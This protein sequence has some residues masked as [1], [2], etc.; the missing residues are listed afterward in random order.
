MKMT[1]RLFV[2][3]AFTLV[4]GLFIG[5]TGFASFVQH[6]SSLDFCT[7]CHEMKD[8]V[9]EEYKKTTHYSNK[10]G[11]RAVCSD[12]HVPHVWQDVIVRKIAAVKD[13]YHHLLGTIDTTEKFDARRLQMAQHVWDRMKA[14]GSKECRNCHAFD[15]MVLENQSRAHASNTK[16]RWAM[17]GP[18]WSATKGLRIS[19]ST[20]NCKKLNPKTIS[21][22]S[23][24]FGEFQ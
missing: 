5:S 7:S 11:V 2:V 18:V 8:S 3:L 4:A 14:N 17:A 23:S 6:T 12:C 1:T 13:V 22:C 24:E 21:I 15:A 19:Q 10:S 16:T 20:I 9:Y